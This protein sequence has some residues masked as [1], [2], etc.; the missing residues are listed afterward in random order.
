MKHKQLILKLMPLVLLL[1]SIIG[2]TGQ[3]RPVSAAVPQSDVTITVTDGGLPVSGGV[4]AAYNFERAYQRIMKGDIPQEILDSKYWLSLKRSVENAT[5]PETESVGIVFANGFD[6]SPGVQHGP[7]GT[8]EV[9]ARILQLGGQKLLE[10]LNIRKPAAYYF[11]QL[12]MT[13]ADDRFTDDN[14]Q[15]I[16]TLT[17]GLS[18][19]LDGR[20]NYVGMLLVTDKDQSISFDVANLDGRLVLSMPEISDT[21][22]TDYNRYVVESGQ[23]QKFNLRISRELMQSGR[24]ISLKTNANLIISD[25]IVPAEYQ[26][27]ITVN[28]ASTDAEGVTTARSISFSQALDNDIDLTVMAYI[29]PTM[30]V[31]NSE[32]GAT[33]TASVKDAYGNRLSTTSPGLML[34]GINFAMVDTDDEKL[35]GGATYLLGKKR[36]EMNYLFDFEKGWIEVPDMAVL[37][38]EEYAHVVGGYQYDIGQTKPLEILMDTKRF[39]YVPAKNR[40]LNQSLIQINGLE[41]GDYFL[42]P[43]GY[44]QGYELYS[45][46]IPF[47]VWTTIT[48]SANG[49]FLKM[50]SISKASS[51]DFRI[52]TTIPDYNGGQ[53]EYNLLSLVD[54]TEKPY[55]PTRRIITAIMI[56]VL[57]MLL[58]GALL[59][60]FI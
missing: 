9:M 50:D 53:N 26:S 19:I 33:M 43:I 6:L 35:I 57:A 21:I 17:Q 40:E 18:A 28:N 41:A 11:H 48:R 45:N 4:Y 55:N 16:A 52:N 30:S 15:A 49:N 1:V 58:I 25:V 20:G 38:V 54:A 3:A 24:A 2:L 59:M 23:K 14:G 39:N 56:I 34:S 29:T 32:L 47:K 12:N 46:P 37:N 36:D 5:Q 13:K 27:I 8:I 42:Y 7:D 10:Q 22:K 31:S 51:Q 44:P 60:I